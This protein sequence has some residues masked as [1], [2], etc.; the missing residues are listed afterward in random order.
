MG[1]GGKGGGERDTGFGDGE[2]GAGKRYRR[3]EGMKGG[4]K[5]EVSV[6]SI[7]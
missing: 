4:E 3:E 6:R 1:A 2:R 7:A 5:G